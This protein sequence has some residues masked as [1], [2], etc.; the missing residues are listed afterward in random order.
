MKKMLCLLATTATLT[1][2]QTFAVTQ[3]LNINLN[4]EHS[5]GQK[6]Y[7]LKRMFNGKFGRG[8]LKGF[9]L[10]KLVIS[11]K[12]KQGN[13]DANL[14]IGYSETYPQVVPGTPKEF[15]SNSTGFHS[16]TLDV[17]TRSQPKAPW[18]LQL[19]GNIKLNSIK[20]VA[21][22]QPSYQFSNVKGLAFKM[23]KSFKVDKIVGDTKKISVGNNFKAIQ[24]TSEGSVKVTKV[25]VKFADGQ[26][27]LIDE[28]EGKLKRPVSFKFA[29]ELSKKVKFIEVSAVSTNL[30]GSRGKLHVSIAD[31]K[32]AQTRPTQPT[33]PTRPVR[34]R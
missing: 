13:G 27:V 18:K 11:A 23:V 1:T 20:A 6:V 17:P 7:H 30:F 34:R 26:T 24:L 3:K 19:K 2:P 21:K 10:D 22:L 15:K 5:R 4:A 8:T 14:A 33:R 9:K 25:K 28:L 12:S 29:K 32:G 31:K 16:I